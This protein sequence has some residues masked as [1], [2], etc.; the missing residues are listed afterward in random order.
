VLEAQHDTY[1]VRL[2]RHD[3]GEEA[4]RW[5]DR[6]EVGDHSVLARGS[7]FDWTQLS[8]SGRPGANLWVVDVDDDLESGPEPDPQ[9]LAQV[10]ANLDAAIIDPRDL[11]A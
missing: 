1:L 8:I 3:T 9:R 4:V 10:L 11:S 6:A 2:L 5:F 7:T